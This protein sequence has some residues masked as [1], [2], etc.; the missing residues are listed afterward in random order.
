MERR[1]L[2]VWMLYVLPVI[3]AVMAVILWRDLT[4]LE[5]E[6]GS[7]RTHAVVAG[8]YKM[9]GKKLVVVVFAVLAGFYAWVLVRYR[10][11]T[12]AIRDLEDK[13]AAHEAGLTRPA[14]PPVRKELP[15]TPPVAT[16]RPS[17]PPA[18]PPPTAPAPERSLEELER[19]AV[20]S[21]DPTGPRFLR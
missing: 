7:Y 8:L 13:H 3:A 21:G 12:R 5:E 2:K 17:A 4:R 9:G 10:R 6:G 19:A 16:A 11:E 18:A 15:A 14:A 20:A 1:R